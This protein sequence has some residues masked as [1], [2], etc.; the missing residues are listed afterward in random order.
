MNKLLI[1][2]A[3]D[4]FIWVLIQHRDVCVENTPLCSIRN[5]GSKLE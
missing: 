2:L 5:G 4:L 1:E 3:S